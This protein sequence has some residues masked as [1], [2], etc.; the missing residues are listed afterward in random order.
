MASPTLRWV[1]GDS[2]TDVYVDN[3]T[4]EQFLEATRLELGLE[5][6]AFT[7]SKRISRVMRP[8]LVC[9]FFEPDQVQIVYLELDKEGEK[10]WDGA[11]L[12][13][14]R[15]LQEM[16]LSEDL[17]SAKRARL[18]RELKHVQRVEFTLMPAKGQDK[19]HAI[20]VDDPSTGSG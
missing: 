11:G 7:L 15:M 16:V 4:T 17:S 19:G 13:S 9:G 6:G 18:E 1:N 3:M 5:K 12:I 20:V 2:V 8:H 14:R 10:V